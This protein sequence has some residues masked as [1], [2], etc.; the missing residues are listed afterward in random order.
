MPRTRRI[1][2]VAAACAIALTAPALGAAAAPT[3]APA[4]STV[5]PAAPTV[6]TT[7]HRVDVDG[8]GRL[9]TVTVGSASNHRLRVGARTARGATSALYIDQSDQPVV[10]D[11]PFHGA[12]EFDGVRGKELF[13]V[14]G[15][16]A[17]TPFFKVIT[18]RNGKLWATRE[19]SDG[20]T[21]WTPDGAW[22]YGMGYRVRGTG[23]KRTLTTT[24]AENN[25]R[26]SY[27]GRATRFT[28]STRANKW[29]RTGSSKVRFSERAAMN[30]FGWHV[31]GIGVW[32]QG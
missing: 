2:A 3:A 31:R 21:D 28:W 26:G 27:V 23:S 16:G 30:H 11:T 22:G 17:H 8:D 4:E 1:T 14:Y 7:T 32:P 24:F 19:P 5:T 10:P 6:T 18:W 15:W 12:A 13:V 25:Q 20:D 29:V 9:D